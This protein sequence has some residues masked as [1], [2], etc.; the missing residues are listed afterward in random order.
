[1]HNFHANMYIYPGLNDACKFV[2]TI[3]P[4]HVHNALHKQCDKSKKSAYQHEKFKQSTYKT[5][6]YKLK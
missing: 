1:M 3:Q 5:G 4:D 2:H 6:G